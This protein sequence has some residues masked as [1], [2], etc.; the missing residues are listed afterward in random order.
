MAHWILSQLYQDCAHWVLF[1]QRCRR[2]NAPRTG[3][4]AERAPI[5]EIQLGILSAEILERV[6]TWNPWAPSHRM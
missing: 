2:P 1:H 4:T 6:L 5:E 3:P